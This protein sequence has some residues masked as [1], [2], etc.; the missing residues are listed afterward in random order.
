MLQRLVSNLVSNEVT[1]FKRRVSGIALLVFTLAMLS[2]A[3]A[4]A[5]LALFL[6]LST[7]IPAWYAALVVTMVI[8]LFSVIVWLIGRSL[9][10][11][12]QARATIINNEVRAF[13]GQLSQGSGKD[14]SK[15]TLELL[16]TA[17]A[18]GLIIGRLLPK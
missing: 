7:I 11:S 16:A 2:L 10:R 4:F 18:I 3:A 12:R 13:M 15:R 9:L 6:W 14:A 5:F 1:T 8:A 17:A